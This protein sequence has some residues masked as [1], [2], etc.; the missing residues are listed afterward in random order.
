MMQFARDHLGNV[1]LDAN[2]KVIMLQAAPSIKV[3]HA[4]PTPDAPTT[5]LRAAQPADDPASHEKTA[6]PEDKRRRL[7]AQLS[8]CSSHSSYE[9]EQCEPDRPPKIE[10][11]KTADQ[12]AAELAA[13]AALAHAARAAAAA[14]KADAKA[15][16]SKADTAG[17]APG[18][19]AS[20]VSQPP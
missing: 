10:Q 1:L 11:R 9:L 7:A 4:A 14:V 20:P 5:P 15:E 19:P 13:A 2:G 8:S 18:T 17:S 3:E 16:G 12:I 6:A